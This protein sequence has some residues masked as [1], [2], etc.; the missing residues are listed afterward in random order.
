MSEFQ[1][2]EF[3]ALDKKLSDKDIQALRRISSRATITPRRF[4]NHYSY[5]DFRGDPQKLLNIYFDSF[6][7]LANWGSINLAFKF[8]KRLIN[9]K[10]LEPFLTEEI[11]K[12]RATNQHVILEYEL[13]E[14]DVPGLL[15]E[16]SPLLSNLISLRKDILHGDFRMLYLGWLVGLQ[17][18][19]LSPDSKEPPLPLG[20]KRLTPALKEF[21]DLFQL[22]PKLIKTAATNSTNEFTELNCDSLEPLIAGLSEKK[23]RAW[24][25]RLATDDSTT[26][27]EEFLKELMPM[28]DS[29]LEYFSDSSRRTVEELCAKAG[30]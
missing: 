19:A 21:V 30:I 7:Y 22:D 18:G 13:I 24:L 25:L 6:L 10:A 23:K 28:P 11:C 27:K 9:Q 12:V 3:Q 1:Y 5:G 26:V 15:E 29:G 16:D 4:V 17:Y 14:C 2:Y 20:L 8:P